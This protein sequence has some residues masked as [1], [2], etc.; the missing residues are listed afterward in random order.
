MEKKDT[1]LISVIVVGDTKVGKSCLI[2]RYIE[3]RVPDNPP[4]TV[5]IVA[6]RKETV[7]RGNPISVEI[8][9]TVAKI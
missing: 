6:L 7:V 5:G 1:G 9:D 8:C 4:A 3:G 2:S